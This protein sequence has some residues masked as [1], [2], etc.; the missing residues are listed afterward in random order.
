MS[1]LRCDG[2]RPLFSQE[3][4]RDG[5]GHDQECQ[6]HELRDEVLKHFIRCF[7]NLRHF[8]G[9]KQN[10]PDRSDQADEKKRL[11]YQS[12]LPE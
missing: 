1:P 8:G 10:A 2:S 9:Q 6:R 12:M 11:R 5:E 4:Q 3:N 7:L